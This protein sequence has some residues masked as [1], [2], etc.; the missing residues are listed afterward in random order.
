VLVAAD[1]EP[2]INVANYLKKAQTILIGDLTNIFVRK[3]SE[4]TISG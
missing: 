3:M 1:S 4:F 2:Y